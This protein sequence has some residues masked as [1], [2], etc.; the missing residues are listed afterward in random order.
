M[1]VC[2]EHEKGLGFYPKKNGKSISSSATT[3]VLINSAQQAFCVPIEWP[4]TLA[5]NP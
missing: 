5:L 3:Q 1:I 4:I 2:F